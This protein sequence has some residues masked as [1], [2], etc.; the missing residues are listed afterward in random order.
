MSTHNNTR[1][2]HN[3]ESDEWKEFL[4]EHSE[5]SEVEHSSSARRF[6]KAARRQSH[7]NT[8]SHNSQRVHR[9]F[10]SRRAHAQADD[11]TGFR[12]P[13]GSIDNADINS[14]DSGPR[15]FDSSFLDTDHVLEHEDGPYVPPDADDPD[16]YQRST[17]V[18][19]AFLVI[20]IILLIIC[21]FV[22]FL[23]GVLGTIGVVG[24]VIGGVGLYLQNK[25]RPLTRSSR[26]LR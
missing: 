2:A 10:F 8:S 26:F 1:P 11:Q 5:L 17:A 7:R 15:D 18:F 24:V 16:T 20:G 4:S 19:A 14:S 23:A 13:D 22:P 6:E 3:E 21:A 9:S 25:N 12:E